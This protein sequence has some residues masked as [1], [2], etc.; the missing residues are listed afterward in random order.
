M[1]CKH[2]HDAP[3]SKNRTCTECTR[4]AVQRWQ[5]NNREI[6]LARHKAWRDAHPDKYGAQKARRRA[7]NPVNAWTAARRAAK[8]Q[9]TPAWTDLSGIKVFYEMA[10][11]VTRCLG[12]PHDVD[13]VL[14]LRGEGVSGL[15]VP[16]NLKV[17]PSTLNTKKHNR[18]DPE[19]LEWRLCPST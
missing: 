3:R 17:I 10:R 9:R 14:P 12:I 6:A 16:G 7:R 5:K 13:H 15:H 19:L 4:L 2:G 8:R 18:V 1:P 11:R